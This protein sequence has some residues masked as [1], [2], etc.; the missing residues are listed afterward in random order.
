MP[1]SRN[2]L[3]LPAGGAAAIALLAAGLLGGCG[4][5]GAPASSPTKAMSSA[6]AYANCMRSHRVPDFPD[7]NGQGEFQL[8]TIFENGRATQGGD[9]TPSSPAF[10]A[11]ERVCGA[12][13]S[14]GQQVPPAQE[15]Q[16]F[17]K[18]LRAAAC[19]RV[20]GVPNYPDP[21]LIGGS[22]DHNFDPDLG[23]NP[24]SPAFEQ[25]A[26]KCGHGQPGLVG[27]G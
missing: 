25:A 8:H 1:G 19:M 13:G 24:S 7:P 14:A 12:F 15:E 10:Q 3:P 23:I 17:Q 9:L 21:T 26:E 20:N 16:E 11:A 27:P 5:S 4:S 18:S 22:I 2:S 6:L